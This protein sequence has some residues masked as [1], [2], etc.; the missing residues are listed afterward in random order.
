MANRWTKV[1]DSVTTKDGRRVLRTRRILDKTAVPYV[2]TPL[3]IF[4]KLL[5][6]V[7]QANFSIAEVASTRL[8]GYTDSTQFFGQNFRSMAPGFDFILGK[9]VDS[10]WLNRKAAAGLI[11]RDS[12]FNYLFQQNF[13]QRITCQR[14]TW[15]PCG[16]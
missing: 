1:K 12:T 10:N 7:K 2:S 4:G 13:D 5:T 11:T 16:T 6:S 15:N 8:P 14:S 3:K 9:Q